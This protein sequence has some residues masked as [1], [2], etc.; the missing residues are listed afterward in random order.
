[1]AHKTSAQLDRE[2]AASLTSGGKSLYQALL[3]AGIQTDHHESDL[4]VLDTPIARA[5][6]AKSGLAM[7]KPFT[8]QIDGKRW[9]D[10]PFAYEPFWEKKKRK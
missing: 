9:L 10:V 5:L 2:I 8:S 7:A 1:M 4:Y 3:A 6:I